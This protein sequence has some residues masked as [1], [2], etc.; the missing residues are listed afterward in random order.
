MFKADQTVTNGFT[1]DSTT[2]VTMDKMQKL[3][4]YVANLQDQ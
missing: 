2:S 3:N 4:E 1:N